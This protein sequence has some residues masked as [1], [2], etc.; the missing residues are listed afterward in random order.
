MKIQEFKQS[1]E[2]TNHWFNL[3]N[4][5]LRGVLCCKSNSQNGWRENDSFH[6][7]QTILLLILI[8]KGLFTVNFFAVQLILMPSY[9]IKENILRH[10]YY[11]NTN[12]AFIQDSNLILII[13]Q[14]L[15]FPLY[16]SLLYTEIPFL[17]CKHCL[18]QMAFL[19]FQHVSI[20]LLNY[21]F[22][23]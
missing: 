11:N 2:N 14:P 23:T 6:K 8:Y 22:C 10:Y 21:Y 7:I 9:S 1:Y 19:L 3:F 16:N 4:I 20:L 15:N 13:Q 12:S 17:Y 5:T 18:S